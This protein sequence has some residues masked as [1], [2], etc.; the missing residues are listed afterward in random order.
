MSALFNYFAYVIV[1]P[2]QWRKGSTGCL[3]G[4]HVVPGCSLV[5]FLCSGFLL[6]GHTGSLLGERTVRVSAKVLVLGCL[7]ELLAW[8]PDLMHETLYL[9]DNDR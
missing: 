4:E 6:A 5:R 1:I 3:Y 8:L 2:L 7:S 9:R